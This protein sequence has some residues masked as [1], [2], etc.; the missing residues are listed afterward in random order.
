M[1]GSGQISD[2]SQAYVPFRLIQAGKDQV[3]RYECG[4]T[5]QY[6]S[7]MMYASMAFF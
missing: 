4:I 7:T 1:P 2:F 5:D 6:N 3:L